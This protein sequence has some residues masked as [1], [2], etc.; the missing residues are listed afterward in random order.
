MVN[1]NNKKEELSVS[2]DKQLTKLDILKKLSPGTGLRDALN[3]I[4]SGGMGAI[5]LVNNSKALSVFDGGFKVNCK[6]SPKRLSELAKLDGGIVLSEDFKKILFVNTLF[7]PDK[8]LGSSE[9]G[10]RHQA[11]ER[12]AKQTQGIVVAVS[13]R[14][15]IIT[16]YYGNSKYVLQNT[17]DL[18]RRATETLR[19]LEKQ[20]EVFDEL[21]VNL[22]VLEVTS[23]VSIA[24]ICTILQRMEMIKKMANIINEY[25]VELGRE[26]IIVRMRMREVTKGIDK[27]QE[28]IIKDYVH[29]PHKVND[30]FDNLS[31]EGLLDAENIAR[32]LFGE[33]SETRIMPKGY[34]I[35]NKTSLNETEV[36]NLIGNFKDFEGILNSNEEK[37]KNVLKNHAESF[38]QE[39]IKLKEQIM[40]GKKI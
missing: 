17:E 19:I 5:I 23:L 16:V 32:L 36:N 1:S 2:Q 7:V 8:N 30:F 12:T 18:L 6:F 33:L 40:V 10:T 24:D 13:E 28:L 11:A 20:R 26:G 22:N 3:D 29:N 27:E 31:F 15:G 39:I 4:V 35:L 21:L 37:L 25:I 38:Q 9:T 34:R 14:R